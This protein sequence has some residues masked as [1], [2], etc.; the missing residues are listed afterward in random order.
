MPYV[1]TKK[2]K[3]V[4][5]EWSATI[6]TDDLKAIGKDLVKV[7]AELGYAPHVL[8]TFDRV[9]AMDFGPWAMFMHS[10]RREDTR[11]PNKAKSAQV[12]KDEKARTVCKMFREL[13][14]NPNIEMHLF[15]NEPAAIAWLEV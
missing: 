4:H 5:L 3:Y 6:T 1:L 10:L 12:A 11:M 15:D 8:H 14:R 9:E 13:N 2:E 7:M